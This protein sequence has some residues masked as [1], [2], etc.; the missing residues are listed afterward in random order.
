MAAPDD[1]LR[2]LLTWTF[3]ALVITLL[4]AAAGVALVTYLFDPGVNR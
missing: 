4:L 3:I 1:G 2:R